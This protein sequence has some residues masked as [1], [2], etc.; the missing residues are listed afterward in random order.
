HFVANERALLRGKF[1]NT[2]AI[3]LTVIPLKYWQL[4]IIY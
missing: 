3:H 2:S 1:W 4:G